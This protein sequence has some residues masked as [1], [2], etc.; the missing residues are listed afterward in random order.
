MGDLYSARPIFGNR[1]HPRPLPLRTKSAVMMWRAYLIRTELSLRS[2]QGPTG[3]SIESF[4]ARPAQIIVEFDG[5]PKGI[6]FRLFTVQSGQESLIE[7][8]GAT[9]PFDLANDPQFQNTMEVTAA[10]CGLVRAVRILGADICVHFRGDSQTGLT[11]LAN[12]MG[13]FKSHRA[14]GVAMLLVVLRES[15]RVTVDKNTTWIQGET[16]NIRADRLS[17]SEPLDVIPGVPMIRAEAG[18]LVVQTMELCDPLANPVSVQDICK[19]WEAIREWCSANLWE[20]TLN[21]CEE[22]EIGMA[23]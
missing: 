21:P 7:E 3:R 19:R 13:S 10:A 1:R 14:R 17:R 6:G 2:G 22:R 9:A 8:W 5:C 18:S 20:S 16:Q 11:W 4:R 12:D 23:L 15:Y